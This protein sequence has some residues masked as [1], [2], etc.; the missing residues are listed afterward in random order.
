VALTTG[1]RIGPYEITSPLGEGGMGVVYRAHDTKLGRDVAIKALPDAFATDADRLQRFQRE[2]QVLASL[3]HPNIAQIYGLEESNQTRCIVMELVEG[4]TLQE[5]L[6]R[7]PIPL[8]EALPMASQIATALEAAHERG[9]VHRDL[10]PANIKLTPDGKVKVLDFGLAKAFQEEHEPT[11]SNSPTLIGASASGVILGTAAYM[12]PEQARGKEADRSSDIW[13]FGC[14]LYE[15]LTGH[16]VFEGETIGEI[17]AGVF[18]AEPDWNRL[19]AQTPEAIRRL[20]R[21]CLQ[22]DRSRRLNSAND[23]RVEIEEAQTDTDLPAAKGRVDTKAYSYWGVT[24]ILAV[25]AL[26]LAFVHFRERLPPVQTFRYS[27]AAPENGAVHSFAVSPDGR[28]V[29]LAVTVRGK[30]EL[31]LRPL[32]ALQAQP[33]PGTEDG[34]YPFWSPDSRYIGFFAQGRLKKIPVTGGPPQS[35]C[36]AGDGRGGSWS[37]KDI[38][39]FSNGGYSIQ[40]IPAAGGMPVDIIK[41]EFRYPV[42]LPDGSHF[43]YATTPGA[44]DKNGIHLGSLSGEDRRILEDATGVA[45]APGISGQL[46]HL[47][48]V[49]DNTLMAQGFDPAKLETLGDAFPLAE[50]VFSFTPGGVSYIPVAV[51][52]NGILIFGGSGPSQIVWFDRAGNTLP[53]SLSGSAAFWEPAISPNEKELAFRRQMGATTDIWLRDL[54]RGVDSRLTSNGATNLDPFWSPNGDRVLFNSTSSGIFDLYQRAVGGSGQDEM[55]VSN[56][57]IKLPDQWTSDG[58]FVVYSELNPKT[59]WDLWVLPMKDN[60]N[61]RHPF[62]FL[63]SEFNELYGQISPDGRWMAYTSDESARREVYVRR[64]P[65]GDGQVRI[66]TGGGEQPRWRRDGKELFFVS[67]EGKLTSVSMKASPL[68]SNA[69]K[70]Q[71]EPGIPMPL[72]ETQIGEGSGHVAFQYDIARDGKRFVVATNSSTASTPLTVVINWQAQLKR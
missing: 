22:K 6:K 42:F 48:F 15:V 45:F 43:L 14:V 63:H 23:A 21:R 61:Q 8:D 32:D 28:L 58:R 57:N 55:L 31:W 56:T 34:T 68:A 38:I 3:N 52:E 64:F 62:A 2:A 33:I 54:N 65:E 69:A 53:G 60:A 10:K 20:L 13:A 11:L 50:S 16:A 27:I 46:G 30:R 39:V 29:A 36:D 4:Q 37:R 26:G 5:R 24:V 7:G 70:L 59:R 71:I 17:L 49:R 9:I 67:A 12:S 18:K 25:A 19:P 41:G 47:F 66:S 44:S 51:S 40:R 35:L 1:S 72:F